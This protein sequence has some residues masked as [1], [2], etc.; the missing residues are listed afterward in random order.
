MGRCDPRVY[1]IISIRGSL[2][3]TLI[4]VI[5]KTPNIRHLSTTL[6]A[7]IDYSINPARKNLSGRPNVMRI[8]VVPHLGEIEAMRLSAARSGYLDETCC[9]VDGIGSTHRNKD[10]AKL[11]SCLDLHKMSNSL[12]KEHNIRAQRLQPT[13]IATCMSSVQRTI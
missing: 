2:R 11:E 8:E 10:V 5:G 12:S 7:I 4:F 1:W 3:K 9:G 13:S 6:L